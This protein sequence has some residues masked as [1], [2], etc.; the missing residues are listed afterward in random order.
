MQEVIGL[1]LQLFADGLRHEQ[2]LLNQP[3]RRLRRHPQA[4]IKDGFDVIHRS[5]SAMAVCAA[6]PIC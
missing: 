3:E 2:A 6:A 5:P 1:D 4:A